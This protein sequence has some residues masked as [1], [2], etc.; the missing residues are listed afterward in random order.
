MLES[1]TSFLSLISIY[2]KKMKHTGLDLSGLTTIGKGRGR[3]LTTQMCAH[4]LWASQ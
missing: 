1:L 2:E 4:E 3:K